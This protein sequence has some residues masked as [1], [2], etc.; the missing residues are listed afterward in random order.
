M[1]AADR[2]WLTFDR[3]LSD[4]NKIASE[5]FFRSFEFFTPFISRGIA[6][7]SKSM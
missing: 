1:K 7:S 5:S 6:S 4:A 3:R 2:W